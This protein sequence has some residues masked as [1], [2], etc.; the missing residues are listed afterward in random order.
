ML[1]KELERRV[2]SVTKYVIYMQPKP[3]ST[4]MR[5]QQFR[6][7]GAKREEEKNVE[8]VSK[9][10]EVNNQGRCCDVVVDKSL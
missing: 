4:K 8:Y 1:D 5:A 10:P 9:A 2:D 7:W 6:S 3:I